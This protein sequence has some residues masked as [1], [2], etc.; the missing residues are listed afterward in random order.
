MVTSDFIQVSVKVH[1]IVYIGY[2]VFAIIYII[3][4][5]IN[6]YA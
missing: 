6:N 4:G 2:V 1:R 5:V 3:Y